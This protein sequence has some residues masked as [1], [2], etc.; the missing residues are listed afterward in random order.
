VSQDYES[1]Y[2]YKVD[3]EAF[4]GPLDLL[5]YLIRQEEVEITDIPIARITEQ[6]LQ[7]I[8]LIQMINVNVAGD[9]LVMA[10]TLM[11]IK[12][13]M[14]LPRP[15]REEGEE[16]DPRADLIRQLLE[17]KKYKDA[18]RE[19]AGRADEQMLKFAR[20][21]A[22]I[23]GLPERQPE[24]D[25]PVVLGEVTVWDLLAAFKTI[26]RQT[27]L[28]APRHV[29]LDDRP[30]AAYCNEL[31][32]KF[33]ERA[34][35]TF[36]ELFGPG[37][38]RITVISLFLA[39][40]ELVRR[41]RVRAEQG[42]RCGEIRLLLLDATPVSETELAVVE[43]PPE[44]EA[45]PHEAE[46]AAFPQADEEAPAM[47]GELDAIAVPE[48]TPVM[49]VVDDLMEEAVEAEGEPAAAMLRTEPTA[50]PSQP[51]PL[52]GGGAERPL[53]PAA[54]PAR[55]PRPVSLLARLTKRRRS[56]ETRRIPGIRLKR[57]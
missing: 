27:S 19:L 47:D 6:Y 1:E 12:S 41:H 40:L 9:F 29:V 36:R 49:D 11:E 10:A 42:E 28:E 7:Q 20:G 4:S 51:A 57:R 18:A 21:A 14:L 25:L 5:L 34:S 15:E 31:L 52:P 39:L 17:Y 24:E 53:V 55:R 23:L 2:G 38:D 45:P 3:L 50:P 8:E 37:I 46:P 44:P 16:E 35:L 32:A 26:L 33:G 43:R 54:P 48:V 13:R 56:A 30:A 22:A